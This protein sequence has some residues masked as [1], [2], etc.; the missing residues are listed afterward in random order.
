MRYAVIAGGAAIELAEIAVWLRW[1]KMRAITGVESMVG[2]TGV[3]IS[4][5]APDGQVRVKGQIWNAHCRPGV[6]A[7][8]S[9]RVTAVDGLR[10]EVDPA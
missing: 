3:A 1:R 2:L 5:C 7:G 10:L 4:D 6:E 9:V 8:A